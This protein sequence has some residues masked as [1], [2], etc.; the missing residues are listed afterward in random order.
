MN[1]IDTEHIIG[2]GYVTSV[3]G[4]PVAVSRY[5]YAAS[6]DQ[7]IVR[8]TIDALRLTNETGKRGA[9]NQKKDSTPDESPAKRSGGWPD[10]RKLKFGQ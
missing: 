9:G 6:K 1:E 3:C 4:V 2:V 10:T 8:K 5:L 7:D